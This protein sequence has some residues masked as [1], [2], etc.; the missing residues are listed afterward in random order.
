MALFSRVQAEAELYRLAVL[1]AYSQRLNTT[2]RHV[3]LQRRGSRSNK[4]IDILKGAIR[5]LDPF[6]WKHDSCGCWQV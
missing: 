5:F 4:R 3:F 2:L 1:P 6:D